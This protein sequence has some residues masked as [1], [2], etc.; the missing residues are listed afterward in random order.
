MRAKAGVFIIICLLFLVGT[1][2]A[3][4][5][6]NIIVTSDKSYLTANGIDQST[7]SVSV[8][9]VSSGPLQG[10]TIDINVLDPSLGTIVPSTMTSNISGKAASIFKVKTKSGFADIRVNVTTIDGYNRSATITQKIDHDKPH[11]A[12]FSHPL[13]GG[14]G[15]TVP[16]NITFTDYYGNAID[17][18]IN[19]GQQ[20][21]INLHVHGPTPD[22][23][24][25]VGYGHD[26]T[27]LALDQ[28]GNVNVTVRLSSG[29]GPNSVTM[30]PFEEIVTPVPRIITGISS[31]TFYIEQQ[32][33]PDSPPQVPADGVNKFSIMYTVYD[34]YR[35]PAS[36]Q[37]V[38]VNTSIPGEETQFKSDTLG[39]IA[40]TYGPRSTVGIINI[41]ATSVF[42][43]TVAI[44]HDVEFTNTAATT[45]VVTANPEYVASRDV[46]PA[47]TSD[48]TATVTDIMG[49]PVDNETVTFSLGAVGYPGG[50]YNVTSVPSLTGMSAIT[51]ADGHATVQFNPGSF[52]T[53][54]SDLYYSKKAT[55]T[56]MIT[57]HWNTT[58]KN[59]LV[60][61]K[62]YPYLSVET[63]V[64][65]QTIQVND[66]VDI[67][68][69]L[70]A[71]GWAL[72]PKPI[73]AV[74][75]TDRSGS[76]LY[77]DP[78]RMYSIREAGKV[79]VNQMNIS[80]DYLGLVTFGRNGY[81]GTAGENSGISYE[82]DNSYHTPATYGDYATVDKTLSGGSI[83]F[84]AV[85]TA[86]DYIVPDHGTPM[87]SAIY[88]SVNEIKTRGRSSTAV[89]AIVLLSDGDFNWYGDP[90]ARGTGYADSWG[91]RADDYSDLTNNYMS[92]RGLTGTGNQFSEENMSVYAKNNGI[93]IYSIAF[94]DS[95][96]SGGKTTLSVL[97]NATGGKYYEASATNIADVYKAIAGDLQDTAGVN[98]TMT[99][100]FQ[101][102]NVTGV[103]VPGTQV[104]DY[105]YNS[106]V[107]TRIT[108]Q[109]GVTNVTN[110]SS[111]WA[112]DNK[113]DFNIGTMKIGQSWEATFRLKVKKAGSI[114]VFGSNSSLVFN[115]GTDIL[116]LPHTFLN[117][118]PDLNT[119]GFTPITIDVTSSC[120]AL[121]QQASILPVVWT[122][123]Y[124]GPANTISEEVLYISESGAHVPFYHSSFPVS[125]DTL[126]TRSTLFD[127]RSVAPGSYRIEIVTMAGT[128][129]A[130]SNSCGNYSYSTSGMTF[131]K[132]D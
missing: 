107:S 87:R 118:V 131:I 112:A 27:G 100:D 96:S 40:L 126:V 24:S 106:T 19:P 26:I 97:A 110:Q 81:I 8:S 37:S 91:H 6:D 89:Q 23:C 79:F 108:W 57:A 65:P 17:Q 82:R 86:L 31:E 68:I 22:N 67:T 25:F 50:P 83:G 20:H 122:T 70:L 5:P 111:E 85:K 21:T 59:I 44:S 30:D 43:N 84:T 38:W 32:F 39:Q 14:V 123:T 109:N 114:D 64:N 45:M 119:T 1:V 78:D 3:N 48:I 120:P 76:M 98:T 93:R 103:S 116:T 130:T 55:G 7:I 132:L 94:A 13:E 4:F 35:N 2:A 9:N 105:I 61:W 80:R 60:T 49:N 42:N 12:I 34:R 62:N 129:M 101:N 99:A 58:N 77:D 74:L 47:I 15:Q 29:A 18:L 52:S 90:L 54:S 125:G 113:L 75:C 56:C 28:Y 104:Y 102:V 63:S 66:T 124:T 92:L 127:M 51:D 33:N 53:T 11:Y 46:N 72:Q 73:D 117:V 121:V 95:M 71:D 69:T 10:V 41:T 128:H 88:K 115:N 16:F 36:Q